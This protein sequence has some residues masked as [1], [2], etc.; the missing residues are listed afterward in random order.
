MV[1]PDCFC[2][3]IRFYAREAA[4]RRGMVARGKAP[5]QGRTQKKA[6]CRNVHDV[7]FLPST[8]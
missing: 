7:L 6:S 1:A 2:E 3:S 4:K 5:R 8:D